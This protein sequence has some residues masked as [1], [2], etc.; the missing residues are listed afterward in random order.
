MKDVSEIDRGK[1]PGF[2]TTRRLYSRAWRI[3]DFELAAGLWGDP[4]VMQFIDARRAFS[5]DDIKARLHQ[6]MESESRHAVQYWPCFLRSDQRPIGCCGIRPYDLAKN[7]YEIGFHIRSAYWGRGFAVEAALGVME[8][9]FGTLDVAGL[10]AGHHPDNT[11]SRHVLKKLGFQYTHDEFYAPTGLKH[12]S[13]I[14][15]R[16]NYL[17]AAQNI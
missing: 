8:Y 2:I 11:V 1:A 15:Y 14:L 12:F 4:Q 9:A 13:Y 16:E 7:I 3:D 5:E 17:H 10:F 6:E